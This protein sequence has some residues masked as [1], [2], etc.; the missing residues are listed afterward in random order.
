M[1]GRMCEEAFSTIKCLITVK[2][3]QGSE[4]S[5]KKTRGFGSQP[6]IFVK[7][8][9]SQTTMMRKSSSNYLL[10]QTNRKSTDSTAEHSQNGSNNNSNNGNNNN[11]NFRVVIRVR[12]PLPRELLENGT[13]ENAVRVENPKEIVISENLPNY[14]G[15]GTFDD[16]ICSQH[17][18]TF[19][20]VY[21]MDSNQ[22]DVYMNTARDA[23]F[24]TLEGYNATIIAYGQT[25]TGK[26]F[27]M[28]GFTNNEK[29]GIIPR[30]TE[31]IF[32]CKYFIRFCRPIECVSRA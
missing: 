14:D 7:V 24:S 5:I 19:D 23:V 31:E 11:D 3:L 21:D 29:R 20:R 6:R 22:F 25:G 30:S 12:P 27:T 10:G 2:T 18:F 28:E 8:Y 13:F 9:R 32:N 16:G 4:L 17:Q 26:T 1:I 15:G